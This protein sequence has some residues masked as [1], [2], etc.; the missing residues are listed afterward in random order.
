VTKL[1]ILETHF[2]L[3]N[4]TAKVSSPMLYKSSQYSISAF[5]TPNM[6]VKAKFEIGRGNVIKMKL[7]RG[8]IDS[9]QLL[10]MAEK[11][12]QCLKKLAK[13]VQ[14]YS[15]YHKLSGKIVFFLKLSNIVAYLHV[16]ASK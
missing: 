1:I 2:P 13:A 10:S 12:Q 15:F 16:W 11:I 14:L 9:K 5:L 7:Q 6:K 8:N 3:I 4:L